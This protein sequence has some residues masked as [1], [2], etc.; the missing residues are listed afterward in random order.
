MLVRSLPLFVS[1]LTRNI[2]IMAST[3]PEKSFPTAEPPPMSTADFRIYNSMAE[4]M[5]CFVSN[6]AQGSK[7]NADHLS[8]MIILGLLGQLSTTPA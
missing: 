3:L 8:S 5:D 4:H 2:A 7:L 6:L 1:R